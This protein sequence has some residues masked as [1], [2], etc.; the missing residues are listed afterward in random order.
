MNQSESLAV[1]M[2]EVLLNGSWI[3]NTN[4]KE[5]LQKISWQQA[6]R[7]IG[8]HNSIAQ[9]IYHINYYI[10][11]ILNVLQGGDLEI[12]D[13][14]SFD[15]APIESAEDWQ[16]LKED[17]L[18][19]ATMIVNAIKTQPFDIWGQPFV[20]EA[21]GSYERNLEGLIEHSYYH[22]GQISLLIKLV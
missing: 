19:N 2:D 9:L 12:R 20:K 8:D 6:K 3:A 14:Y 4:I 10:G 17:Y 16:R 1:R 5:Q 13:K 18:K 21:Y 22:F 7:K 11:G 15:M